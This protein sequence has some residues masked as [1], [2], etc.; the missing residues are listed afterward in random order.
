MLTASSDNIVGT[1]GNDSIGGSSSSFNSD[2]VISGG[3]GA[4]ALSV[5]TDA[6]GTV[7][8]NLTSVESISVINSAAHNAAY[9]LNMIGATGATELKSRLSTGDVAFTSVQEIASLTAFGTQGALAGNIAAVSAT[10]NNTLASGSADSISVKVDGG[11]VAEFNATGT[12]TT[13]GFETINLTSAG[14][15]ANSVQFGSTTA[16]NATKLNITGAAALTLAETAIADGGAIDAS[17]MTGV[18][19]HTL[20]ANVDSF[21]GGSGADVITVLTAELSSSTVARS[22]DLGAGEDTLVL[23]GDLTSLAAASSKTHSLAAETVNLDVTLA[24]DGTSTGTT[25]ITRAIDVSKVTGLTTLRSVLTNSGDAN[26]NTDITF[27]VT[28]LATTQTVD[29]RATEGAI[30]TADADVFVSLA[31]ADASGVA[32]AVNLDADGQ[33]QTLTLSDTSDVAGTTANEAG[34]IEVLNV[35][36]SDLNGTTA[37]TLIVG[38]LTSDDV[39]TVNLTGKN[40]ITINALDLVQASSTNAAGL[41]TTLRAAEAVTFDSSAM[42][43]L[44]SLSSDEANS[45]KV[46]GGAGGIDVSLG[47]TATAATTDKTLVVTG[48]SFA[49]DRVT[50]TD[51]SGAAN[52][53]PTITGV[54]IVEIATVSGGAKTFDMAKVTGATTIELNGQHATTLDNVNGQSVKIV[55]N[56]TGTVDWTNLVI[57]AGVAT[58]VTSATFEI[59]NAIASG[60]ANGVALDATVFTTDAATLVVKDTNVLYDAT[61]A[62]NEYLNNA[63]DI[64]GVS[65]TLK[66]T[67]LVIQ[68]GGDT[69]ASTT[70]V[71]GNTHTIVDNS[72]TALTEIDASAFAGSLNVVAIGDFATGATITMGSGNNTVTAGESAFAFAVGGAQIGRI[73]GGDGTDTLAIDSLGTVTTFDYEINTTAV[74]TI[75]LAL[76]DDGDAQLANTVVTLAGSQGVETIKLSVDIAGTSTDAE[77]FDEALTVHGIENNA[78]VTFNSADTD[79]TTF[80]GSTDDLTL[81]GRTGASTITLN[82]TGAVG[83]VVVGNGGGVVL[84]STFTTVNVSN[85]AAADKALTLTELNGAGLTTINLA[86]ATAG[87]TGAITVTA[88]GAANTATLTIDSGVAA[89]T[90]SDLGTMNSLETLTVDT[91]DATASAKTT[92]TAGTSTSIDAITASGAG[93]FEITALTASS[94]D[95]INASGVTGV[96]TLG[97]TTTAALT[98]AAGASIVTGT[99]NDIVSVNSSTLGTVTLGSVT[100]SDGVLTD[101]DTLYLIGAQGSGTGVIDLSQTGDQILTI[102]GQSNTSVQTGIDSVNVASM[103]SANSYGW[104]ITARAAG[105]TITGS[106]YNDVINGGAGADTL[107][108]GA[109]ADTIAT[110]GGADSVTGGAGIDSITFGAG[111]DTLILS[112]ITAAADRDIVTGFTAASDKITT[113]VTG[114]ASAKYDTEQAALSSNAITAVKG[115]ITEITIDF[116]TN[117]LSTSTDGTAL[118]AALTA[119]NSGTAAT[120]TQTHASDAQ[121]YLLAYQGGN[122]YLYYYSNTATTGIAAAEIALVGVLNSVTANALG[123][124]N[125]GLTS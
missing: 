88:I 117:D 122:A 42:T 109:G 125:F 65:S 96:V 7:I 77:I 120:I 1:S 3:A 69:D 2:D 60:R 75:D 91:G 32:D 27:N 104:T 81:N 24:A 14:S 29:V 46:V 56:T 118:I 110:N 94:L 93:P 83:A 112:S 39:K 59:G 90:V 108:G 68:G 12:T 55:T 18:L 86:A 30:S 19:T 9:T 26:D 61:P 102:N 41:T 5:T 58:G 48:G 101:N 17:G 89:V 87:A 34:A 71:E 73:N 78:K 22:V 115:K 64:A 57:T 23:D 67:K 21:K 16:G 97:N 82:N 15:S 62:A 111:V 116:L 100:N 105:S 38:Q 20:D 4:D 85:T 43:A 25:A 45:L 36:S 114:A 113:N 33:V 6:S 10:F 63:Y 98:T 76:G 103:T 74:E 54:E 31:L 121:G 52:I 51:S 92:I 107:N 123:A 119:V 79:Q 106:G 84:G 11:A 49:T 8:A 47:G 28:G 124:A 53:N 70:A 44:F 13:N 95:S 80:G 50:L 66:V 40:T 37:R 72:N 35:S 99:A